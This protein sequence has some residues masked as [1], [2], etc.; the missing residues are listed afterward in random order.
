MHQT[1]ELFNKLKT[2]ENHIEKLS[3]TEKNNLYKDLDNML[4]RLNSKAY[5]E[6]DYI[7]RNPFDMP[8]RIRDFFYCFERYHD[9]ALAWEEVLKKIDLTDIN[10]ILD[11][12]PGNG[13][14]AA[15]ALHYLDF[16][17]TLYHLDKDEA[18]SNVLLTFIKMFRSRFTL[19]YINQD[20]FEYNGQKVDMLIANHVIDDL[21][22]DKYCKTSG[23]L[24]EHIYESNDLFLDTIKR[25]TD[26]PDS[27]RTEYAEH[28]ALTLSRYLLPGGTAIFCHYSGLVEESLKIHYWAD[29]CKMM[30]EEMLEKLGNYGFVFS[31]KTENKNMNSVFY[32]YEKST[33]CSK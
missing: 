7:E 15:I 3:P 20:F 16:R 8:R 1:E 22:I 23:V 2:I 26:E 4:I 19:K 14:K 10:G 27:V 21:L 5:T 13:P 30:L 33:E 32:F 24:L 9:H 25:I 11:L 28:I 18:A 31:R 12:C 17:G 29:Y 6:S